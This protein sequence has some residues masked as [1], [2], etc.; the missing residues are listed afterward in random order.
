VNVP[1]LLFHGDDDER[2]PIKTS[3]RFAEARPDIV[4]YYVVEGAGHVRAWNADPAL[5]EQRVEEFLR[6]LTGAP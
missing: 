3:D 5:Y 1:V 2:A 6:Q 4:T